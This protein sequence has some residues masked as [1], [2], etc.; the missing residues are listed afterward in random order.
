MQAKQIILIENQILHKDS[1]ITLINW[2]WASFTHLPSVIL[3]NRVGGV[4]TG[5]FL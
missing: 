5:L 2:R 4:G 3:L 1:K